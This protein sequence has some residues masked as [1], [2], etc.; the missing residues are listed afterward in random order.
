M[1]KLFFVPAFALC[2]LTFLA[3][4]SDSGGSGGSGGGGSSGNDELGLAC[5]GDSCS[6]GLTCGEKGEQTGQ[7]VVEGCPTL[8]PGPDHGCPDNG[9][10]FVFDSDDGH[11]CA[12]VCKTD[13]DCTAV[14]TG[15]RC[16]APDDYPAKICVM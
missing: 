16:K 11:Y 12:R 9:F 6:Q 13:A 8:G 5:N 10:C 4:G 2:A 14:N 3:C 7:C 1:F 15:L